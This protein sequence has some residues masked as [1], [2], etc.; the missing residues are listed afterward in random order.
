MGTTPSNLKRVL[1]CELVLAKI[2]ESLKFCLLPMLNLTST[3]MFHLTCSMVSFVFLFFVLFCFVFV[4]CFFFYFFVLSNGYN[5]C[6]IVKSEEKKTSLFQKNLRHNHFLV[7]KTLKLFLYLRKTDILVRSF[8]FSHYIHWKKSTYISNEILDF[9]NF[10]GVLSTQKLIINV[11]NVLMTII[12]IY[13]RVNYLILLI[14]H[15][16]HV[17]ILRL[18]ADGS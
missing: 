1:K 2:L 15:I 7:K 12:L 14:Q 9:L 8:R 17:C 13:E 10:S 11:L 4:F 3:N 16:K 5:F 18:S 6:V